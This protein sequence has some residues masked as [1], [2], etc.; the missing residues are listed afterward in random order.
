VAAPGFVMNHVP[1]WRYLP[2]TGPLGTTL[3]QPADGKLPAWALR[4]AAG[5]GY[6]LPAPAPGASPVI[7]PAP[8][9]GSPAAASPISTTPS[10]ARVTAVIAALAAAALAALACRRHLRRRRARDGARRRTWPS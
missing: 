6:T 1:G 4:L 8:L 9:A 7:I 10:R 3:Y 2:G 5:D